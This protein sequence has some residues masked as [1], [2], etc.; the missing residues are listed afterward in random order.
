MS[1]RSYHLHTN[2]PPLLPMLH[3]EKWQAGSF[4]LQHRSE[5]QMRPTPKPRVQTFERM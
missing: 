3:W 1:L 5:T 2:P 4:D